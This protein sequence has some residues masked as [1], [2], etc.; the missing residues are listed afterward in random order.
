MNLLRLLPV[1][2]LALLST[3]L[4]LAP[5]AC[6]SSSPHAAP[7]PDASTADVAPDEGVMMNEPDTAPPPVPEGGFPLDDGGS[8][9]DQ[10]QMMLTMLQ[11]AAQ[12]CSPN[13]TQPQCTNQAM[14]T[15]CPVAVNS[16]ADPTAVENFEIA[17]Q[18]YVMMCKPNCSLHQCPPI[19]TGT[20]NNNTLSCQQ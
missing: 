19:H 4:T 15:C 3:L 16:G 8:N 7:A 18:N 5:V 9:C 17:V 10:L 13:A 1:V 20:C 11:G 6:S 2:P 12:T 14:G